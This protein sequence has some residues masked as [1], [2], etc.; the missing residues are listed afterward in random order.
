MKW[1]V[2]LVTALCAVVVGA[3]SVDAKP[4]DNDGEQLA[5][6]DHPLDREVETKKVRGETIEIISET[7]INTALCGDGG[8]STAALVNW[9]CSGTVKMNT[10]LG[11]NWTLKGWQSFRADDYYGVISWP[12]YA[13]VI[14]AS[15][16]LGWSTK[17]T[18]ITGPV[19]WQTY[20]NGA[21][22]RG[23]TTYQATFEYRVGA[24]GFEV[25]VDTDSPVFAL[26]YGY[27]YCAKT[28]LSST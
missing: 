9:T 27:R 21:V 12:P 6:C 28:V 24:L 26:T 2:L 3:G 5:T 16:N 4:R 14:S 19:K 8:L 1:L 22:I 25:V 7:E 13:P 11:N 20:P 23:R 15:A 10:L 18:Q 17:S